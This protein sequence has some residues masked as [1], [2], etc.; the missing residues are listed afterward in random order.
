MVA[1]AGRTTGLDVDAL[2]GSK[3]EL[4]KKASA[5]FWWF[6]R[7]IIGDETFH[8]NAAAIE[9]EVH[10][11]LC[12]FLQE[13]RTAEE[14]VHVVL[15]ARAHLK[16]TIGDVCF[17]IWLLMMDAWRR[18]SIQHGIEEK[19]VSM[20][21]EI[22]GILMRNDRLRFI[23]P[24][25]F[26]ANPDKES[27]HWDSTSVTVQRPYGDK[28][29]SLTVSGMTSTQASWHFTDIHGDDLVND[30]NSET[31]GMIEKT[32]RI[33]QDQQN[34]LRD[35]RSKY[36]YYGTIWHPRDASWYL[37]ET[38]AMQGNVRT[39][40]QGCW[41]KETE[42]LEDEKKVPV[43]KE[44]KSKKFLFTQ[45]QVMGPL[46]FAQQFLCQRVQE[47]TQ[48]FRE[49]DVLR[50]EPSLDD[51]MR[52]R[53][54]AEDN[55]GE[56]QIYRLFA[57]ID[58]NH[59]TDRVN[60]PC[61]LLVVA[62]DQRRHFWVVDLWH[63]HPSPRQRVAWA[64]DMIKRWNPK[65]YV[66][67]TQAGQETDVHMLRDD[68]ITSGVYYPIK[69]TQRGAGSSKP[70]RIGALDPLVANRMLHVPL[71]SKFEP[72]MEEIRIYT[73]GVEIGHDDCLDA[74]AD[75]YAEGSSPTRADPEVK[76]P[77]D[78]FLMRAVLS[79]MFPEDEEQGFGTIGRRRESSRFN[80]RS[81]R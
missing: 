22:Q 31:P 71:G 76:P 15:V 48:L 65:L 73:P 46:K 35:E 36:R 26:Y 25:V 58:P 77:S 66:V 63:G 2:I 68:T 1:R 4:R 5:S 3:C 79:D 39:F 14:R 11:K 18:I 17:P 40:I 29:P 38:P 28:V 70:V 74:L 33:V 56:P 37:T 67:E 59:K 9:S 10:R 51:Q 30:K 6:C 47:G 8:G 21:E 24:D 44:V 78:P 43:W 50:W 19:A 61:A 80:M 81:M 55:E 72:L 34:L 16:T 62:I 13:S 27:A 57:A 64:R 49:M 60:D 75:I 20:L 41:T 53:L 7:W 52:V 23:A 45:R 42:G 69:E 32:I 12:R 54:P